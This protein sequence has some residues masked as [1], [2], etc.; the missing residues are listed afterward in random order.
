M[1]NDGLFKIINN[2]DTRF[3]TNNQDTRY[4]IQTNLKFQYSISKRQV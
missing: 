2:Q 4:K 1:E 3:N